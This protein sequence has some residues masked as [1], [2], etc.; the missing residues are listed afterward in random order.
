MTKRIVFLGAL[1]LVIRL[2]AFADDVP[3][4]RVIPTVDLKSYVGQWYEIARFPNR[5]QKKCAGDVTAKYSLEPNGILSVVN[6]CREA[7]GKLREAKGTAR[8]A[9]KNKPNSILKVRFAPSFL[10][11]LPAVWG[12]YQ[13]LALAPD[14]RYALVGAP[15]R[16][17]LWILSRSTNLDQASYEKLVEEAKSQ[18]FDVNQLQKTPQTG[19]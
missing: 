9:D 19:L 13:I 17:Y 6:R 2:S 15:N 10:S 7:N 14:Y 16:Q 5:F 3:P 11:F 4:L 1:L 12:D 18:G 8:P